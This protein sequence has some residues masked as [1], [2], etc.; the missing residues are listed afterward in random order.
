[1]IENQIHSKIAFH[2]LSFHTMIELSLYRQSTNFSQ[3]SLQS[4]VPHK[5]VSHKFNVNN[6]WGMDVIVATAMLVSH[7][8]HSMSD[9]QHM[10]E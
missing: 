2:S 5:D 10:H 8:S 9:I 7:A 6:P 1:M 4:N 3:E